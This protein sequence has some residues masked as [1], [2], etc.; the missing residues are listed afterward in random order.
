MLQTLA[1]GLHVVHAPD[2]KMMGVAMGSRATVVEQPDGI[3]LI[4]PIAFDDA[5]A[6]AI[7]ALGPVRWIVAPNGFHHLFVDAARARWPDASLVASHVA[8]GKHPDWRV[9]YGLG[10][11]FDATSAWGDGLDAHPIEGAP[12]LDETA[13]WHGASRTLILTD[14][15]FNF[16]SFA[17]WWTGVFLGFF[18][19]R[20]GPVQTKILRSTIKDRAA[21]L[22]ATQR[23]LALEP[24][25]IV[26]CHGDVIEAGATEA[27]RDAT[28]WMRG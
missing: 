14:F 12:K 27:L 15:I 13:F 8:A 28:A 2:F 16:S 20:I 5:T 25:R 23:L 11:D 6:S 24:E 22:G 26:V 10:A 4:S 19:A 7:D 21:A 18:G 1:P 17:S 9:D 3:V